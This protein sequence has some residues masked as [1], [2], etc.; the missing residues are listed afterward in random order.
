MKILK[1][2]YCGEEFY[3]N[4]K[5]AKYCSPACRSKAAE[6][7]KR[8]K[9]NFQ[10]SQLRKLSLDETNRRAKESGMSYGKY[11]AEMYKER[12]KNERTMQ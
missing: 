8:T 7:R 9:E 3:T 12:L 5:T 1:C 6:E 4:G 10:N 2:E 11:V